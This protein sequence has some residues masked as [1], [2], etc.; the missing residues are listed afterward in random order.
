MIFKWPNNWKLMRKHSWSIQTPNKFQLRP[1]KKSEK[2]FMIFR[3]RF[4]N[5]QK[6]KTIFKPIKIK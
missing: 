5:F 6:P 2:L 1:L 3:K 4:D